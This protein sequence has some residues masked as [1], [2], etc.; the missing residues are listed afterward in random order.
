MGERTEGE[1]ATWRCTVSRTQQSVTPSQS[2]T[3]ENALPSGVAD[4]ADVADIAARAAKL[5]D[6]IEAYLARFVA[7]PSEHA[8]VAHVLWIVHTWFIDLWDNTPRLAFMSPEKE[9]G[10]TRALEVTEALVPRPLFS[11]NATPAYIYRKVGDR[12]GRPTILFD[13][14]DTVFGPNAKGNE[15]LRA[16]F[17]SGF[18]PGGTSGRCVAVNNT[19]TTQER[20]SYCAVALAGLHELPDTITS[21]AVLIRMRRRAKGEKVEPWRRRTNG[22]DG[23]R[24]GREIAEW[25][26]EAEAFIN[27][28]P[29]LPIG[30][31]DRK[32]DTWEPLLAVADLAGEEWSKRARAAARAFVTTSQEDLDTVGVQLLRDL[33]TV[34]GERDFMYTSDILTSLANLPEARWSHF[35]LSGSPLN[36]RDLARELRAYGIRSRDHRQGEKVKKGYHADDLADAWDRYVDP[37]PITATSATEATTQVEDLRG[38]PKT[39]QVANQRSLRSCCSAPSCTQPS[40]RDGLC[41]VHYGEEIVRSGTYRPR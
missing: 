29:E 8:R 14:I 25:S 27:P 34:F 39:P 17:N 15:D 32:A 9:S 16:F 1:D 36:D 12:S 19:I 33:R 20:E 35:H 28:Y 40:W 2:A 37:F 7:Y 6:N 41:G 11:V 13:E 38:L 21:R 23:A 5:F 30:I 18:R 26:T 24:L 4:V 10:K 3:E 31:E 22:P